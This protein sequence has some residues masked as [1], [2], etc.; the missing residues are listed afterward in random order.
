M[1]I[2][3]L[4]IGDIVTTNGIPACS[5]KGD[6][7]KIIAIDGKDTFTDKKGVE[8]IGNVSLESVEDEYAYIGG[9]WVN[10][11]EP[12]PITDELLEKFGIRFMLRNNTSRIYMI[13]ICS[14]QKIVNADYYT[15]TAEA[16]R[17]NIRT[18][19]HIKYLHELQHEM[20]DLG[21]ELEIKI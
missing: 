1:D 13:G 6:W 18:S 3:S 17:M 12:I 16:G 9:A 4:R 2:R 14:I 20:F 7:Y 11:L 8:H 15:F 10:Y 19:K 5:K 21:I